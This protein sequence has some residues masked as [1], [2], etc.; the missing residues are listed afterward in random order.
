[1]GYQSKALDILHRLIPM[2]GVLEKKFF[3][4]YFPI[5]WDPSHLP[6]VRVL[7]FLTRGCDDKIGSKKQFATVAVTELP[8]LFLLLY[9]GIID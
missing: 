7:T 2:I 4:S 9:V 3:S 5:T 1:M 8:L 6:F